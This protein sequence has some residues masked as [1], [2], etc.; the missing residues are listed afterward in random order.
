M[1]N[2]TQRPAGSID[3][4]EADLTGAIIGAGVEVHRELGPGLRA[5]FV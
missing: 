1:M 2:E 3:L 4:I 5:T